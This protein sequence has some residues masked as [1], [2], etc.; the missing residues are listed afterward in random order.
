MHD[1]CPCF[2][3]QRKRV[4][5][6]SHPETKDPATLSVHNI[7]STLGS[8]INS[9]LESVKGYLN[10][11]LGHERS[12]I[13]TEILE[14]LEGVIQVLELKGRQGIYLGDFTNI[15]NAIHNNVDP[16]ADP[17][18]SQ[19]NLM[20]LKTE[21]S[22]LRDILSPVTPTVISAQPNRGFVSNE[23]VPMEPL[24]KNRGTFAFIALRR[25]SAFF[26]EAI[27][28]I[29]SSDRVLHLAISGSKNAALASKRLG[30]IHRPLVAFHKNLVRLDRNRAL[31][32]IK[33]RS[34]QPRLPSR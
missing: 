30:P 5:V 18:L 28:N 31:A 17:F 12:Q 14:L 10:A 23:G 33:R 21:L 22:R 29:Q 6:P 4:D 3:S 8:D 24:V 9:T 19:Q 25:I 1:C 11:T 32:D 20:K 16:E 2:T 34:A 15:L 13:E 7:N 27:S 26:G